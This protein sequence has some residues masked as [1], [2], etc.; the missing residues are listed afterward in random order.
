PYVSGED[1]DGYPRDQQ[2]HQ[3]NRK[4]HAR[5]S[6][7]SNGE[8]SSPFE[9]KIDGLRPFRSHGHFLILASE[10]GRPGFY[11]VI[12]WRDSLDRE[13]AIAACNREQRT[14]HDSDVRAHPGMLV[15]LHGYHNL[16][17]RKLFVEWSGARRLRLVPFPVIFWHRMDVVGCRVA[18]SDSQF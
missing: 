5:S 15:A 16:S 10:G 9:C 3:R 12:T 7:D 18:R 6:S 13:S 11:R 4:P 8:E 2:Q 14:L 1:I 17:T